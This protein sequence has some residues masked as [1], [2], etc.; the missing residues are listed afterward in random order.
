[1]FQ[2][3]YVISLH[4]NKCEVTY[5]DDRQRGSHHIR[6]RTAHG[7][8]PGTGP[9]RRRASTPV[10]PQTAKQLPELQLGLPPQTELQRKEQR[11]MAPGPLA[12]CPPQG[13]TRSRRGRSTPKS[14]S[15]KRDHLP[16][17]SRAA[18]AN[19][20]GGTGSNKCWKNKTASR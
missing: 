11:R 3:Q 13:A 19:S 1:M 16:P 17:A 4:T 12:R 5:P 10:C 9:R 15:P 20:Q 2:D 8:P 6:V 18:R 14:G 7:S